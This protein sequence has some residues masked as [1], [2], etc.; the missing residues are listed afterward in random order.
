ML[1]IPALPLPTM[2]GYKSHLSLNCYCKRRQHMM[3]GKGPPRSIV[4]PF[5]SYTDYN[6]HDSHGQLNK[7]IKTRN[8]K[9]FI[10]RWGR[11]GTHPVLYEVLYA[12]ATD[13]TWSWIK[14]LE[15]SPPK[16]RV[17]T[18]QAPSIGNCKGDSDAPS[19]LA[20]SIHRCCKQEGEPCAG[21]AR[22]ACHRN[23]A[24]SKFGIGV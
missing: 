8:S 22:H 10:S 7:T 9:Y 4:S 13:D 18:L 15:N 3:H 6:M 19:A 24:W 17:T 12:L 11:F 16:P 5:Q 21:D 1:W 23:H 14:L 20:S 2:P